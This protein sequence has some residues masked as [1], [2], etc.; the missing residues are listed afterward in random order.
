MTEGTLPLLLMIP[1]AACVL[2]G[3]SL[4]KKA[5]AA[6]QR[7]GLLFTAAG[8]ALLAAGALYPLVRDA[9]AGSIPALLPIAFILLMGG[10]FAYV[11]VK[12]YRVTRDPGDS[13][14]IRSSIL[15]AR[16]LIYCL[17]AL[18]A[19][20][21]LT[22]IGQMFAPHD[23]GLRIVIGVI[24][25]VVVAIL[26]TPM[27]VLSVR[28]DRRDRVAQTRTEPISAEVADKVLDHAMDADL[29]AEDARRSTPWMIGGAIVSLGVFTLAAMLIPNLLA[30][31]SGREPVPWLSSAILITGICLALV[32]LL[33][34]VYAPIWFSSLSD[35]R[36][37][38]LTPEE[39]NAASSRAIA[40]FTRVSRK[41][42]KHGH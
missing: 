3:F 17:L 9:A 35:Y 30:Q 7:K 16:V 10:L 23:L 5:G 12:R 41:H 42:R 32:I 13:A 39:L 28:T 29:A 19:G 18:A 37:A 14:S 15:F 25:G 38:L 4:S 34:V 8:L 1:I 2:V 22:M 31:L 40:E 27:F 21:L 26:A 6:D 33:A 20:W 24:G 11:L 36:R